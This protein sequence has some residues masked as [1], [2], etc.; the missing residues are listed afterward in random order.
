L[1]NTFMAWKG[2]N[3]QIDDVTVVGIRI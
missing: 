1:E 3:E 2:N